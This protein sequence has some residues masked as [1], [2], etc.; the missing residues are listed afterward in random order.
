MRDF[1]RIHCPTPILWAISKFMLT[2]PTTSSLSITYTF[3]FIQI[4]NAPM[5]TQSTCDFAW[6]MWNNY[7][8]LYDHFALLFL[9][10]IV[11]ILEKM[12]PTLSFRKSF[13]KFGIIKK[14]I[15][16]LNCVNSLLN[17]KG[18]SIIS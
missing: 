4:V 18:S 16:L 17:F 6:N 13:D 2:L 5:L 7:T 1:Q 15:L 10:Q 14:M 3:S 12:Q 8:L 11:K 9:L